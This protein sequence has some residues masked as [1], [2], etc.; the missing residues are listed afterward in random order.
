MKFVVS[1]DYH[2]LSIRAADDL[3]ERV[4]SR[5]NPVICIASGESPAGLYKEIVQRVSKKQLDIS[6]WFF[7]GLD[8]WMGMNGGDEGSCRFHLNEQFF[9]PLKIAEERICFFDGRARDPNGECER[10]EN[11]IRSHNGIDVA[12]LGLGMNGHVGMNEPG[13]P[14]NTRSHVADLHS[15][16]QQV[17]QKYFKKEQKLTQGMTLGLANLMESR[18]VMLLVNGEKKAA[19]VQKVFEDDI[20]EEIP[21]SLLRRHANFIGYLDLAAAERMKIHLATHE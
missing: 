15:T 9:H 16:T 14:Q 3:I 18:Y 6:D 8:E 5:K 7:L 19:I 21:A 17:G 12:I 2:E 11:F 4:K 13:T 10:I 1:G 20:S